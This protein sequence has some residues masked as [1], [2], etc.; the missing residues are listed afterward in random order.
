MIFGPTEIL[1]CVVPVFL[2]IA[3]IGVTLLIRN[4]KADK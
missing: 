2:V 1:I 3:V 4:R